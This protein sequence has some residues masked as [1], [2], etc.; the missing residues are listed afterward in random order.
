MK[1]RHK[2]LLRSTEAQTVSGESVINLPQKICK[3]LGWGINDLLKLDVIK[4][5]ID[6][7]ILLS[8]EDDEE[9]N[10]NSI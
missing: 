4:S 2:V 1:N 8:K 6:V 3:E 9:S 7:S 10:N 5:G